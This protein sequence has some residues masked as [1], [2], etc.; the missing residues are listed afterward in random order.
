MLIKDRKYGLYPLKAF[1]NTKDIGKIGENVACEYLK[2]QG[3]LV[4]ERNYLR[5]WGEIDIIATKDKIIHFIEVKSVVAN[6]SKTYRPE[7]NVHNLKQR[8]LK[9]TIQTYLLDRKY[10]F[11]T[12]F[13]FHVITVHLNIVKRIAKVTFMK[14]IIL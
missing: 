5:K 9:R 12:E 2:K 11:E 14:N 1:M 7:E 4:V 10:D 8:R 6:E 13:Q 3:F